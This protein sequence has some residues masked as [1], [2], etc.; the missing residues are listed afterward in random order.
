VSHLVT[1]GGTSVVR[2]ADCARLYPCEDEW[3]DGLVRTGAKIGEQAACPRKC[4]AFVRLGLRAAVHA[5]AGG[6]VV[7]GG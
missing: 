5:S 3:I 7:M 6:R 1:P 2:R 4:S